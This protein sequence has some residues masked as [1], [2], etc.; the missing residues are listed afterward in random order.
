MRY[1]SK[2]NFLLSVNKS[3]VAL[4][5]RGQNEVQKPQII[6]GSK[7]NKWSDVYIS[8]LEGKITKNMKV[9][10]ALCEIWWESVSDTLRMLH[11]AIKQSHLDYICQILNPLKKTKIWS[12][13]FT[14]VCVL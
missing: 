11:N 13:W 4:L 14:K 1:T 8:N 6:Y 9:M 3:T 7:N 2:Q 12:H 10:R 5:S